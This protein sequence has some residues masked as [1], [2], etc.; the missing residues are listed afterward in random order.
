MEVASDLGIIPHLLD[1][2]VHAKL[3]IVR[4]V[5]SVDLSVLEAGFVSPQK[6]ADELAVHVLVLV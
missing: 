3:A 6:L 1:D 2:V 4:K 5:H